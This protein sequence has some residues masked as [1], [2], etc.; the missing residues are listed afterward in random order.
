LAK[1]EKYKKVEK[2]LETTTAEIEGWG[3]FGWVA[4][5]TSNPTRRETIGGVGLMV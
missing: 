2:P 3:V 5:I 4:R 1:S